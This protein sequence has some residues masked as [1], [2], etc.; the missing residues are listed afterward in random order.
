[1]MRLFAIVLVA[2]VVSAEADDTSSEILEDFR[3]V[4]TA[5]HD[6]SRY[7]VVIDVRYGTDGSVGPIHAEIKCVD[8]KRCARSVGAIT[9]LQTP[10]W[11]IAIDEARHSMTVGRRGESEAVA[12]SYQDPNELVRAWL[13]SGGKISGGELSPEGRHWSFIPANTRLLRADL[14]TDP[15]SHLLRRLVY[16][17][18]D[19]T[20]RSVRVEISYTW[21]DP[22]HLDPAEFD[23]TRYIKEQGDT[24][25]PANGYANY[26]IIRADHH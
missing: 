24:I 25:S 11:S 12:P 16:E 14:Y 1:M 19:A 17:M 21:N 22:S 5:Y 6:L 7:D 18:K 3:L 2:S 9:V 15:N 8:V 13:E 26:S 23:E 10:S 4:A 20:A